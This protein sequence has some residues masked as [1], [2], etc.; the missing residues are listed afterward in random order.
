VVRAFFMPVSNYRLPTALSKEIHSF[1]DAGIDSKQV[2]V[3]VP[4][5]Q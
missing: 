1:M 2:R 4:K 3:E 5:F